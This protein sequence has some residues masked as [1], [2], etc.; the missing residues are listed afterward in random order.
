MAIRDVNGVSVHQYEH[1]GAVPHIFRGPSCDLRPCT[2]ARHPSRFAWHLGK[3]LV[4]NGV[5]IFKEVHSGMQASRALRLFWGATRLLC[6][7][8]RMQF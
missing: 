7:R 6:S 1:N 5:D 3:D 4:L 8:G 2:R